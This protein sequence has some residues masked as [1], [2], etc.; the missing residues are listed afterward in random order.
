MATTARDREGLALLRDERGQHLDRHVARVHAFVHAAGFDQ[1]RIAG[2]Q[3]FLRLAFR[4]DRELAL[5]YAADQR[6]GMAV[7]AFSP[8][9]GDRDVREHGLVT[10]NRQ[11]LLQQH[12]PLQADL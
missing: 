12:L 6:A 9:N 10:R 4:V 1:K 7:P 11:V 5:Q 3:H 2:F 8:A